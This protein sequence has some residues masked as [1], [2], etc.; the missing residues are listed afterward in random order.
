[1]L[2]ILIVEDNLKLRPALKSGL[3]ALPGVA[4]IHD[5]DTGEAAIDFCLETAAIAFLMA[6]VRRISFLPFVIYR[7]ALAA[8]LF[9]IIYG[10][11]P[12]TV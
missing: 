6:V 1:M 11:L 5:C 12:V 7:L 10:W 9:A 8:V 3:D 2:N 4:V